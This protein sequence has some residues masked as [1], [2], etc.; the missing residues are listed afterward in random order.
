[1]SKMFAFVLLQVCQF[2]HVYTIRPVQHSLVACH[3]H[4]MFQIQP[5]LA[6]LQG[7]LVVKSG[8]KFGVADFK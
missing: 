8:G 4:I 2:V 3:L 5:M 7:G 6:R 1:M